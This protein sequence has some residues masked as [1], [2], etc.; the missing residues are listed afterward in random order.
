MSLYLD[1]AYDS[2]QPTKGFIANPRRS[3]PS[4]CWLIS[5]AMGRV[6]QD[7]GLHRMPPD[8]SYTPEELE[9]R[10]RLFWLAYVQDKRV[11]MKMGRPFILREADC[12]IPLPGTFEFTGIMA[13]NATTSQGGGHSV[14]ISED[15]ATSLDHDRIARKS[16]QTC[17]AIIE[18]CKV[19][20]DITAFRLVTD[21]DVNISEALA[22]DRRLEEAWSKLPDEFR[23]YN[24]KDFV[25]LPAIRGTVA[26]FYD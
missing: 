24:R 14:P 19:C 15:S 23:D 13:T 4:P 17:G 5:G 2:L 7:I 1:K 21:D 9:A 10:I 6:C 16:L 18:A 12:N 11:A 8:H 26:I 25:D 22:I 20:E 3:L